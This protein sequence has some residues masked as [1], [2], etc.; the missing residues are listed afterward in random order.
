MKTIS[1][2][3]RDLKRRQQRCIL[4]VHR[5]EAIKIPQLDNRGHRTEWPWPMFGD[6]KLH[7]DC[8]NPNMKSS[9]RDTTASPARTDVTD[10]PDQNA[11]P[12]AFAI[13]QLEA[14]PWAHHLNPRTDPDTS[15]LFLQIY[16]CERYQAVDPLRVTY[17]VMAV[18]FQI[19][20]L[21][22]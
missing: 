2:L 14:K 10:T 9:F 1:P 19:A 7:L 8:V 20:D 11:S 12:R 22:D 6:C 13:P 17:P 16:N 3:T 18:P 4:L 5:I 15:A 21:T